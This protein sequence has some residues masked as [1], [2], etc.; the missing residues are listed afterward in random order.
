[1][2]KE[3]LQ[4]YNLF[5]YSLSTLPQKDKVKVIRQLFGYK[6]KKNNKVYNHPGLTEKLSCIKLGQNV[7]CVPVQNSIEI[8]NFFISKGIKTDVKEV[9]LK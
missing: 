7:I 3:E 4:H 1:M 5:T 6:D 9:W 8:S 2:N